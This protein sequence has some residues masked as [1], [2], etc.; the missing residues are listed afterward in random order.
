M[1]SVVI[2][3]SGLAGLAAARDLTDAGHRVVVLDKGRRAGGRLATEQF[4]GGARADKGAQFFTVRGPELARGVATWTDEGLVHEWCRGFGTVDGHPRYAVRGGTA[5]LAA[6]LAGGLDVR[7]SVHVDG[8]RPVGGGWDVTW[9]AGHGTTAGGLHADVVVLTP[10]VP[11]AAVLLAGAAVAVPD[12]PYDATL[13]LTLALDGPGSVPEPGAV[14]PVDDPVW[15]WVGD[16]VAKGASD[17]PAITLHTTSAVAAARWDDD[18]DL[19][20]ATG[21]RCPSVAR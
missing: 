13:S 10:P 12:V 3:G 2:V 4:D 21:G 11:Q 20:R 6:R 18:R 14:Q 17:L 7:Q 8:V 9:R 1:A 5:R 19:L 16:N 15:S